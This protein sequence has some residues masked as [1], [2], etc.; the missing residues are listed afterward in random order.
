MSRKFESQAATH[1]AGTNRPR[2]GGCAAARRIAHLHAVETAY[3]PLSAP[4]LQRLLTARRCSGPA[5][6][7]SYLFL[8]PFSSSPCSVY[9]PLGEAECCSPVLLTASGDA[10]SL[11]RCNCTTAPGKDCGGGAGGGN[12]RLLWGF[13]GGRETEGQ[14]YVPVAP[15][16]CCGVCLGERLPDGGGDCS[17]LALCS[18]NG[19]CILGSCQCYAG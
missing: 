10:I 6:Y 14:L 8:S 13:A 15:L 9:Y 2:A 5:A 12:D 4:Y 19:I 18:G 16:A 1:A 11:T 17:E 7:P 3:T